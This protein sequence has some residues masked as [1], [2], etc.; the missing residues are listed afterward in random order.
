MNITSD[1]RATRQKNTV[2]AGRLPLIAFRYRSIFQPDRSPF[3][4]AAWDGFIDVLSHSN[5]D[6]QSKNHSI[7]LKI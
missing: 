6:R 3:R 7:E 2:G 5:T 1:G 4:I